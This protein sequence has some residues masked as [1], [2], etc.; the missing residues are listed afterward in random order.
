MY[1][2]IQTGGKQ[3]RVQVGDVVDVE[4]LGAEVGSQVVFDRVL[5]VRAGEEGTEAS[6]G[7]PLVEGAQVKGTVLSH[8]RG[9]KVVTYTYKPRQ[10]SNRRRVGHRQDF[11]RVQIDAIEG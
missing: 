1:A 5:A 8:E 2:V 7:S 6:L 3:L 11:Y 9:P 4:T 10:N